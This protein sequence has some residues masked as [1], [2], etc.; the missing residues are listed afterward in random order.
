[1]ARTSGRSGKFVMAPQHRFHDGH[2]VPHG[3]V[4]A[5]RVEQDRRPRHVLED[6]PPGDID[7]T[8]MDG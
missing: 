8:S 5:Q 6:L 4:G 2:R 3:R 1:M 7:T